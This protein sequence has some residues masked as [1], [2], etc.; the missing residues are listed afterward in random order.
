MFN[1]EYVVDTK[2]RADIWLCHKCDPKRNLLVEICVT[3]P[4][5]E[6]KI[7]SGFKIIEIMLKSEEDIDRIVN[8]G[9]DLDCESVK[10]YNFKRKHLIKKLDEQF[11]RLTIYRD[12]CMSKDF[13]LV[14][15]THIEEDNK[16]RS[17]IRAFL[18]F[19]KNTSQR[20]AEYECVRWSYDN[21]FS[22]K[23]CSFCKNFLK[24]EGLDF[25]FD[26][27]RYCKKHAED[28]TIPYLPRIDFAKECQYFELDDIGS[29]S[30]YVVDFG[31]CLLKD[32][33]FA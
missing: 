22:L 27:H 33:N 13:E 30:P 3:H 10:C 32:C 5:S 14:K 7:Q 16:N 6:E 18:Y 29:I 26:R 15:C 19:P 28:K 4:C 20:D 2:L 11:S 25:D 24:M 21:S 12:G 1:V 8:D 31:A 9:I 23:L 17:E